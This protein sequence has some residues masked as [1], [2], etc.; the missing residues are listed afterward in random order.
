MS[1]LKETHGYPQLVETP[2]AD[3][4]DFSNKRPCI[5]RKTFEKKELTQNFLEIEQDVFSLERIQ[6]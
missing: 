1:Y 3:I 2:F 4:H 6:T 5:P